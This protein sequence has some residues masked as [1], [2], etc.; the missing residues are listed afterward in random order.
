M[1]DDI[2]KKLYDFDTFHSGMCLYEELLERRRDD[3]KR[4]LPVW[5]DNYWDNNG[6]NEVRDRC[7]EAASK[8]TPLWESMSIEYRENNAFD[9]EFIPDVVKGLTMTNGKFELHKPADEV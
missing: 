3:S 7:I 4:Y 8:L 1:N 2:Y 5:L 6:T 9:W